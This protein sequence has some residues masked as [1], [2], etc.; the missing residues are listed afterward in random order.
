VDLRGQNLTGRQAEEALDRAGITTNKNAI[1]FDPQPPA[2]TSGLRLGTPAVTTRGLK[3]G[4]MDQVA[5]FIIEVLR[6]PEDEA[7]LKKVRRK[8]EALCQN[9][10]LYPEY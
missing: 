4:D 7:H 2:V 3:E 5:E 1:P 9:F 10:P 8:V 6:S